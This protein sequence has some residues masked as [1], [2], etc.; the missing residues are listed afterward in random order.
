MS[1]ARY[2]TKAAIKRAT[3]AARACGIVPGGVR[4]APDGSVTI[5]PAPAKP[6]DDFAEW[7]ASLQ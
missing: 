7:E 5:L 3:E 1:R 2:A 4:L 6:R